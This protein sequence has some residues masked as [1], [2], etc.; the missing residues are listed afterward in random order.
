MWQRLARGED[1]QPLVAASAEAPI[2]ETLDLEWP[3]EG[4]EP[5]SFVLARMCE[6][7]AERLAAL[8]LAA[9]VLHLS[10]RLVSRETETR[11]LQLP[12]PMR[13][14][15]VLRT[16]DPA[17]PRVASAAGRRRSPDAARGH[18]AGPH[19][20]VLAARAGA[21]VSRADGHA[22]RA[23]VGAARRGPRGRRPP[24]SIPIG[25]A[26]SPW[27][28]FPAASTG[29]SSPC[30]RRPRPRPAVATVRASRCAA[31]ACPC[32]PG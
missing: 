6:P 31:S 20:A 11:E 22:A 27:R 32:R 19:H 21:A 30:G 18:G 3:V 26:R 10:F 16:L 4:L 29:G 15:K 17:A 8:D 23:A 5:L 9:V 28:G 25:R 24:S 14:P 1:L 2:E 13:D 12:A 7:L